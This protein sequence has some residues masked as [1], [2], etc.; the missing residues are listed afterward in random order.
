MIGGYWLKALSVDL[1]RGS[2]GSLDLDE[3]LA[4]ALI[5]GAG[6]ASYFLS[7]EL[8]KSSDPRSP[9]NLL[10]FAT[11]PFQ[12][13]K[14]PG[15][16]KFSVCTRSPLTGIFTDSAAGG[17]F[18]FALKRSGFDML[19]ISG[20]S[21]KPVYLLVGDGEA[22]LQSASDLWG[23]DSVETFEELSAR[24][25]GASVAAIG[26]A[27]ENKVAMACIYVDGFSAAGRGGTGCVMGAKRL[28]AVVAL[29]HLEVPLA[30]RILVE[31]YEKKFRKSIAEISAGFR[32]TGTV[33]GL[34]AGEISGNLPLRN[35]SQVGWQEGAAKIGYPGYSSL[36]N[37][38][39]PCKYCT[40]SCH[41]RADIGFADG[42]SYKGPAPEYETLA[43]LGAS[44]LIDDME[45]LLKANDLCN[46]AGLDTISAGSCA[47][48]AMEALEKG[49]TRGLRPSYDLSWGNGAG[50]LDFL[51]ELVDREGFGG[52]FSEGIVR[53]SSNFHPDA[54]GY[55]HHV[56]G[57][58]IPGHDPR[59]Y[60]NL[61]LSY[62]TGNRGACHMRA[63]SQIATMGAL[64]PEVGIS[65]APAPDTL[66]GAAKVVKTYQDF[67]AFYN[68]CVL[69]QFM[70]WGGFGLGDMTDCLNAVTGWR[71]SPKESLECG[72]RAFTLQRK[73]NNAWGVTSRDDSLPDRFFIASTMGARAGKAPGRD[74]FSAELEE[75]YRFRGW[76]TQGLVTNETSAR[77]GISAWI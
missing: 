66:D 55:A 26:T 64:L 8:P 28:K 27:G 3:D 53:A 19:I 2:I 67:T 4:K 63:Y 40:I 62:A 45:S 33:G 73:L 44:C 18:G 70:I 76:D 59:V 37:K 54:A 11:G 68:S 35:W 56:K 39:H 43:M 52:L 77:L 57:L 30:D 29:G 71:L 60:Y 34:D 61:G 38:L 72:E 24:H 50:L 74:R 36:N 48:F 16:A 46:R 13:T 14:L 51:H 47:A 9:A 17:D 20:A 5:G 1:D 31:S 32:A 6:M 58:D 41:R 21:N 49:H 23:K 22:S 7:R 10:V 69:C 12:S 15:A 42:Y 65:V 75:L 25:N